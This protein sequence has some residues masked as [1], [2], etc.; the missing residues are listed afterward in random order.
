MSWHIKD[1]KGLWQELKI[2]FHKWDRKNP[3]NWAREFI[4]YVVWRWL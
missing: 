2:E 3:W 4:H 1:D